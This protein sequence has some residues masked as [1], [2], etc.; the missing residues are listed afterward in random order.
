MGHFDPHC[1]ARR[2]YAWTLMLAVVWFVIVSLL[3][4][5][6]ISALNTRVE[7]KGLLILWFLVSAISFALSLIHEG[8][9]YDH[10]GMDGSVPCLCPNR[11]PIG[12]DR[13]GYSIKPGDEQWA[14]I[15]FNVLLLPAALVRGVFVVLMRLASKR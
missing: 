3:T 12:Y 8:S 10:G 2:T 13:Y 14:R 4:W 5:A 1:N 6:T 7:P 9:K 15:A 11:R